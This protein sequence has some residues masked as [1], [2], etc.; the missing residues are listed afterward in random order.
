[1]NDR[2]NARRDREGRGVACHDYYMARPAKAKP[3]E[4]MVRFGAVLDALTNAWQITGP[5]SAVGFLEREYREGRL[6]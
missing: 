3:D 2:E 6:A 4:T 1:V 5:P